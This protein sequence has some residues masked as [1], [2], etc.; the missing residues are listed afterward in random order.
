MSKLNMIGNIKELFADS[1]VLIKVGTFYEAYNHDAILLSFLFDYKLREIG[2]SDVNCGF[3]STA[4]NKVK[5]G[6]ESKEINYLIVDKSHSYEEI[7]KEVFKKNKYDEIYELAN[8][9]VIKMKRIQE[10]YNFL[11]RDSSK[12]E[13]VE[14]LLYER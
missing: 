2:I 5:T 7:E 12:L 1:V 3:P 14:K 4:L 9:H 13:N 11:V 10:V 8:N 6:L